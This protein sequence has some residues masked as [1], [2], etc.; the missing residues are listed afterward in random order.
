V[1]KN[2]TAESLIRLLSYKGVANSNKK[3]LID[4][5]SLF[6][7]KIWTLLTAYYV[8]NPKAWECHYSLSIKASKNI[9]L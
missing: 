3:E 6:G 2:E 9:H 8:R 5:L 1:P 4:A 7:K